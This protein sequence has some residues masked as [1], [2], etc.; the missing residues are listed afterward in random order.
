VPVSP[1]LRD[2]PLWPDQNP[3][4]YWSRLT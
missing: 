4:F 2:Y 3:R 1:R